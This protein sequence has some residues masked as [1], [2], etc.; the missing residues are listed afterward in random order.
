MIHGHGDDSYRYNRKIDINFSSNVYSHIDHKGLENLLTDSF[1]AIY[2]Y[3]EPD[4]HS[5][6]GIVSL[7]NDISEDEV[8]I[9]NGA[10]EA[11]Y[12]IAKAFDRKHS[13][14]LSP[15]F[16]EYNDA[17]T[18]YGHNVRHV[19]TL[20]E[21]RD[22]HNES[23]GGGDEIVWICNPNNPTGLVIENDL[24]E[25]TVTSMPDKLFVIDQ[26]YES[27]SLSEHFS[28]SRACSFSNAITIHSLTKRYAIPG[29]RIGYIIAN[30]ELTSLLRKHCMPWSVNALALEAGKYLL[31]ATQ[32]SLNLKELLYETERFRG[33]LNEI[34]GITALPTETHYFLCNLDGKK[35]NGIRGTA[36]ELKNYLIEEHGLLIRD[37]SNFHGLDNRYFRIATQLKDENDRLINALKCWREHYI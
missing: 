35:I 4:G 2:S 12:I 10:T 24:L 6:A 37:A 22:S 7:Q 36:T 5:L 25:R 13:S 17:C 19:K 11:I 29:L 8:I 18:L 31:G 26:S 16:S 9:T 14:I 1:P 27:F 34:E 28:H 15:T 23:T 20:G 3:P 30:K 33:C 21:I 32:P